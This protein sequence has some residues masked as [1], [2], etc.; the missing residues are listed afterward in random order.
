MTLSEE[1]RQQ[2]ASDILAGRLKPGQQL[3]ENV[4]AAQFNVSRTP[5]RDALRELGG[6]GLVEVRPHRGVRVANFDVARMEELFEA[7]AEVEAV[8]AQLTALRLTLT[9]RRQL[10]LVQERSQARVADEDAEGYA[11]CDEQL[12]ELIYR[13][14]R[15]A[16][17]MDTARSLRRRGGPFRLPVFYTSDNRM[18]HSC[19]EHA[20][21]V[22]AILRSDPAA[23]HDAMQEHITNVSVHVIEYFKE[24]LA[25]Q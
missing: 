2:I 11:Q 4:L 13:G 21:V 12:H 24:E 8:C 5:V 25:P 20:A 14:T 1:V 16:I 10:S 19:D 22:E 18:Q 7:Q 9:D 23:A 3:E 17:L 15:N 6:T